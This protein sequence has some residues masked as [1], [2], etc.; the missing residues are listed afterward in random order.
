MSSAFHVDF[1]LRGSGQHQLLYSTTVVQCLRVSYDQVFKV[2]FCARAQNVT[3]K[4]T[5][6]LSSPV[7]LW[8]L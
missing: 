2:T 7:S 5:M 4:T 8:S 3:P 6:T 1:L